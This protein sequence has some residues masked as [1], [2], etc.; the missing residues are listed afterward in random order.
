MNRRLFFE[1]LGTA[2]VALG[3]AGRTSAASHAV[4]DRLRALGLELPEPPAAAAVYVPFRVSGRQV[5]IAGQIPP[6]DAATPTFGKLG[7]DLTVEQGYNAARLTALRIL[8]QLKAACGGDL[9]RV[10][11]CVQ[12]RGSV[13]CTDD[14]T[15]QPAV[16]NG[17][18]ELLRDLFGDAGLAARAA[19][20]ANSLPLNAAVEIESVFEIRG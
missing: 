2:S 10:V 9:D 19:L 7:R 14:F 12:L 15:E 4:E 11:Q 13:N 1:T 17:A 18:S 8:A 5:F 16:I 3:L 20:G 6:E